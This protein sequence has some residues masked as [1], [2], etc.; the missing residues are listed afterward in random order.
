ME[1]IG[2]TNPQILRKGVA[3]LAETSSHKDGTWIVKDNL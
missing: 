1:T 2:D 3:P